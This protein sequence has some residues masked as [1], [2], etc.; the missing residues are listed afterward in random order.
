MKSLQRFAPTFYVL[1]RIVAGFM[2]ACH[3][4]Q[5]LFGVLG[6]HP[7]LGDPWALVGGIVEFAGGVLIAVGFLTGPAAFISSG[8]MAVAY[9]KVHA[10]GGFWPIQNHGELAALY[11]FVFLYMAGQGSGSFSVDRLL[12]R[13]RSGT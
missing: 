6:G 11:A 8:E 2:F 13:R 7:H 5:K 4:A 9:F 3:G 1:L 12:G 10:R